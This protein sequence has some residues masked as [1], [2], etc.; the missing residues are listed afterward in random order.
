MLNRRERVSTSWILH[1]PN[2]KQVQENTRISQNNHPMMKIKYDAV[3]KKSDLGSS[4]VG[5]W[6]PL[7]G[8]P[9]RQITWIIFIYSLTK[10]VLTQAVV[11]VSAACGCWSAYLVEIVC[12]CSSG[13]R[14]R[15]AR[16]H[17]KFQTKQ[18]FVY[19]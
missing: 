6:Y 2:N 17:W 5:T 19:Q 16:A 13:K 8:T 4:S 10:Y 18:S 9:Q 14:K 12:V 11:W 1:Y 7:P 15:Y 3:S